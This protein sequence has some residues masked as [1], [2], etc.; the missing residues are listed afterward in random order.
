VSKA[1]KP[2][3]V[4]LV[5]DDDRFRDELVALVGERTD[6]RLASAFRTAEA[7]LNAIAAGLTADVALIDLG[8]PR[9][10]GHELIRR[11]KSQRPALEIVVLTVMFDDDS[12]YGAL[13]AGAS[14]YLLK[15][16]PSSELADAVLQVLRGGA[17][18]SPS[19]ARRILR[20]FRDAGVVAEPALSPRETEVLKLLARGS[21]YPEIGS[22]LDIS[23]STVQFHIRAIYRKLEVGTKAEATAEAFR[24]GII[25]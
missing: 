2:A 25:R 24:R 15:G 23:L 1:V 14:G 8:L 19:I 3:S 21:S 22:L 5:E 11:L 16:G 9:M 20:E 12:L 18:M 10:T 4:I 7:A 17:P 13:R 6:L